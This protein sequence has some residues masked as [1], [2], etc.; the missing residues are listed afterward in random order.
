MAKPI[1]VGDKFYKVV[2][3]GLKI[4]DNSAFWVTKD[5]ILTLQGKSYDQIANHLGMPLSSQQGK[6]FQVSEITALRSGTSFSSVIAPTTE[7]G[8]KNIGWFQEAG[9][10]QTLLIDRSAFSSPVPTGLKFP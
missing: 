9:G 5:E 7:I 3:E 6:I 1:E 8:S 4:G 2:T 10:V